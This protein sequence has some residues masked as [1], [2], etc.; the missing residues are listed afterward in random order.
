[1]RWLIERRLRTLTDGVRRAREELRQLDAELEQVSEE[2]E[3]ARIRA[4]V[5]D[6][7]MAS[8]DGFHAQRSADTLVAARASMER[9]LAKLRAEQDELLDKLGNA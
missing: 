6:D 1:M 3:S 2:A 7:A 9:R 8:H 5:A 4:I